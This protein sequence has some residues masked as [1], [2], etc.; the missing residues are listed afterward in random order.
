MQLVLIEGKAGK[1]SKAIRTSERRHEDKGKADQK[2]LII[3]YPQNSDGKPVA[4]E[5]LSKSHVSI[6]N[7]FS[8]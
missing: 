7:S 2:S 8:F 4:A 6:C 3:S 5:S 1:L